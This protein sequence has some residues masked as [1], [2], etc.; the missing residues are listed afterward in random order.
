MIVT[1]KGIVLS[2]V[3]Y[4]ESSIIS[5]IFTDK[6]GRQS[7]AVN[8]VRKRK[9]NGKNIF[10]QPLS[11]VEL[12]VS[13]NPK[14]E[15]QHIK[16][17]KNT[18]VFS[19]IPFDPIRSSIAYFIAEIIYK[20]LKLEDKPTE[21]L[22][23]FINNSIMIF[24]EDIEGIYNFHLFFIFHLTKLL[25]FY[26][27]MENANNNSFFDMENS[28]FCLIK[29]QH[30]YF[31]DNEELKILKQL[32]LL[33]IENINNLKITGQQRSGFIKKMIQYYNFNIPGFNK[34]KSFEVLK[35]IF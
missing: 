5:H 12:E 3:K 13:Y 30:S 16:D 1:T 28:G 7:Y 22:F 15:I 26:P 27:D 8:G 29:P 19:R 35:Q 18:P 14:K 31:F 32:H 6:Y 34:V 33:N 10:M 9:N 24:D 11:L 20:S 2:Y 17:F 4:G 25:G 21:E 23:N